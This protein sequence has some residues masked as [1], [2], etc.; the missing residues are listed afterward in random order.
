MLDDTVE[1]GEAPDAGCPVVS[2]RS[3][4]P[5]VLGESNTSDPPGVADELPDPLSRASVYEYKPRADDG[6]DGRDGRDRNGEPRWR[7]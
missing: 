6:F 5:A 4:E 1:I 2:G 3:Q 7:Q